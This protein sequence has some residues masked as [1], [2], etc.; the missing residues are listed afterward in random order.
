VHARLAGERRSSML[1]A[2]IIVLIILWLL[3]YL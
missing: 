2:I 3:G 1:E